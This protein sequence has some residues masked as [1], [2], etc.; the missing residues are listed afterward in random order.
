VRLN[1]EGGQLPLTKRLPKLRGFNNR[2]KVIFVP[3]NLDQL[4]RLFE[5]H[6]EVS[7]ETLAR[8]GLLGNVDDPVVVLAR[9]EV[10]KP[11]TVR[12]QRISAAA[13]QKIEAAGGTV[14][15]LGY[16]VNRRLPR[17]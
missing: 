5:A 6:A 1:F 12:V 16:E 8:V 15:V 3:V 17:S 7:Q 13:R 10:T 9:G 11:L 14:E 2:F 4:D